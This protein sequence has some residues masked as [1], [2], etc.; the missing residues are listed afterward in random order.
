MTVIVTV[1]VTL[2]PVLVALI[3]YV[4]VA[5]TTVGVP[6][7]SPVAVSKTRPAGSAGVIVQD[8]TG[9]PVVVGTSACIAVLLVR[10]YGVPA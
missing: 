1:V 10:V 8:T 3:V 9:P 5:L 2:P 4:L 6:E 7:I